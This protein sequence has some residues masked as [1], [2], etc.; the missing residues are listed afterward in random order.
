MLRRQLSH[1]GDSRFGGPGTPI[2]R[3]S[4]RRERRTFLDETA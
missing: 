3:I 4:G 1:R 2:P